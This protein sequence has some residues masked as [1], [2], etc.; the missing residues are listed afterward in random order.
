MALFLLVLV[1]PSS[2]SW[3]NISTSLFKKTF[4]RDKKT[5]DNNNSLRTKPEIISST[6]AA[7][8]KSKK[9]EKTEKSK[10]TEKTEKPQK[11]EKIE[12]PKKE[13]GSNLYKSGNVRVGSQAFH[14]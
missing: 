7:V 10:K 5:A 13:Q 6:P 8:E 1:S 2:S 3:R 9:T 14:S 11:T 12:K 4:N